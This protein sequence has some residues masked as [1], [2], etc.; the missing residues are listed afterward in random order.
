MPMID[1]YH[2]EDAFTAEAKDRLCAELTALLLEMEGATDNL[3]SRAISWMF[4][5]PMRPGDMRVGGMPAQHRH[6]RIVFSVPEGT[7]GLHGPLNHPRR[8][9]LFR[10]ATDLVLAAEGASDTPANR[11]R[12]WCFLHEVPDQSW[13]GI[14]MLVGMRDIASFVSE[15]EAPT[16]VA[17]AAREA[18]SAALGG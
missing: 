16:P 8:D 9:T 7:R 18:L 4:C 12:V 13:G 2:P 5:H 6:Y 11:F 10:R 1:L 15:H 3:R 17:L 14:G